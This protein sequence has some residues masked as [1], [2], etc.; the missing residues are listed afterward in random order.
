MNYNF[1]QILLLLASS[2]FSEKDVHD[3]LNSAVKYGPNNCL[4][5][6]SY[7][8]QKLR[9][10]RAD[11]F[12]V[13]LESRHVSR[14]PSEA[15]SKIERLLLDEAGLPKTAAVEFLTR[16]LTRRYPNRPVPSE[17]R[18][19]FATWIEKLSHTFPES[20]LLHIATKIRNEFVH[21]AP[22]DWRLK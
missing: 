5:E 4:R 11:Q 21:Q 12:E 1:N 7:A 14:L 19:G 13:G 17:S 20:E 16:E 3:F 8:R 2:G 9:E 15:L 6:F 10:L 22:S 18:K